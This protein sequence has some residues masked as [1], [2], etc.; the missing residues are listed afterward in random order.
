MFSSVVNVRGSL[1]LWEH[2]LITNNRDVYHK[3]K[4]FPVVLRMLLIR[5]HYCRQLIDIHKLCRLVHVIATPYSDI[6][7]MNCKQGALWF[8]M[9][10]GIPQQLGTGQTASLIGF[11]PWLLCFK[12]WKCQSESKIWLYFSYWFIFCNRNCSNWKS[13]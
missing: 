8:S 12:K 4:F 9:M 6:E 1:R 2:S 3:D 5:T 13:K 10:Q 7:M 11:F